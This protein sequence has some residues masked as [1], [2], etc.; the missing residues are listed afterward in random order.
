METRQ[1]RQPP[2]NG[3]RAASLSQ[4]SGVWGLGKHASRTCNAEAFWTHLDAV[5]VFNQDNV[6]N[7][8]LFDF[9]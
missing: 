2:P 5:V 9:G 4:I 7:D 3:T 1:F 6:A 8:P